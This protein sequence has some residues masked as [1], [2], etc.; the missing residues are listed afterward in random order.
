MAV[1]ADIFTLIR[2][3]IAVFL[4]VLGVAFGSRASRTFGFIIMAG[5]TSDMVDGSFAKKSPIP[6]RLGDY[7]FLF[8]MLMVLASFIY[9]LISD[10]VSPN[11][12]IG[13]V[14]FA[15]LLIFVFPSKSIAMLVA[16]PVVVLPFVFIYIYDWELFLIS[17]GWLT[18][19]LVFNRTR[20]LEVI[21]EFTE[22]FP[23][24]Y[25]KGLGRWLENVFLESK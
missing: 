12:F 14:L 1:I 5:W 17:C 10:F 4:V 3:F 22:D 21:I 13:Y 15:L 16:F 2:V 6:T 25:L 19:S 20:F 7:D 23:G 9:L 18:L 11:F 8:D 24:G